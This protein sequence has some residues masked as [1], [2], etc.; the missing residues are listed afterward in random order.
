MSFALS[1][2]LL[3]MPLF[4]GTLY[5]NVLDNGKTVLNWVP[6]EPPGALAERGEY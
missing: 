6:G 4:G 1:A 3:I 2:P 5:S